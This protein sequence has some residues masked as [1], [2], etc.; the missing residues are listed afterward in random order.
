MMAIPLASSLMSS[1]PS[2]VCRWSTRLNTYSL[3]AS[4]PG[5]SSP[6]GAFHSAM[7]TL[8]LPLRSNTLTAPSSIASSLST[9]SSARPVS[10]S[11]TVSLP[12]WFRSNRRLVK[13]STSGGGAVKSLSFATCWLIC[14]ISDRVIR[15][16]FD[17]S[18]K[19][20]S[21]RSRSAS[22][23]GSSAHAAGPWASTNPAATAATTLP[24]TAFCELALA[25]HRRALRLLGLT[26][27]MGLAWSMAICLS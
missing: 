9:E 16:S 1:L 15:P 5:A 19:A 23:R 11:S 3:S 8:P 6:K 27:E 7:S 25:T 24:A 2:S 18:T 21:L 10:S 14:S 17:E 26:A 13:S 4:P 22:M 12:S 20:K